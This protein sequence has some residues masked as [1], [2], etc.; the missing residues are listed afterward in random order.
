M[1]ANP[2]V[3]PMQLSSDQQKAWNKAYLLFID[4]CHIGYKACEA[5]VV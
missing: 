5:I 1:G 2:S 4:L 3:S